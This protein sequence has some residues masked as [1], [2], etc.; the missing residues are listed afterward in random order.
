MNFDKDTVLKT[1][2][3]ILRYMRETDAHDIFVNINSDKDVLKYFIDKYVENE[4][5]MTLSKTIDLCLKSNRYLFAVELNDTR[6]VIGMILQCSSPDSVFNVSEIG[7]AIGKAHWNK[8][9][10]SEAAAAMIDFLFSSGVHKV[11]AGYIVGNNASKRVM[12]KC[13]MLYECR[14]KEEIFYNGKYND[15]EY[16]YLINDRK[17]G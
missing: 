2:R 14:R 13:G 11:T 17:Q 9:Y 6:E 5:D 7:F 12:E 1:K 10:T 8:G 15:V 3:L 4:T 16:Y